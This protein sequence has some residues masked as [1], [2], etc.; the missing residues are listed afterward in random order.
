M[1]LIL[2]VTNYAAIPKAV[3]EGERRA[4][5]IDVLVNNAGYGHDGVLEDSSM[6]DIQRQF[7][8]N[9]FGPVAMM[10]A[11]LPGMRR[12]PRHGFSLARTRWDCSSRSS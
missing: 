7:A 11:V 12:S 5:P 9:A 1:P 10:K 3:A 6:D 8:A 4:G 2:D